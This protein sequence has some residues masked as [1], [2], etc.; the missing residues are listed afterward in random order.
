MLY[1]FGNLSL[2][3]NS[4]KKIETKL[5]DILGVIDEIKSNTKINVAI[6]EN[7]KQKF[8]DMFIIDALIRNTDRHN[9]NLGLFIDKKTK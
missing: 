6:R 3:I 5:L 9:R 8:F 2:S 4:D 7:I 1:E